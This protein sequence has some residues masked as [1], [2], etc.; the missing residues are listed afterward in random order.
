[1]NNSDASPVEMAFRLFPLAL[2]EA[3]QRRNVPYFL[4]YAPVQ[5]FT[6][7]GKN[8]AKCGGVTVQSGSAI[9]LV[10]GIVMRGA[11]MGDEP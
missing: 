3:R 8:Q 10:Q 9:N 2:F 1:M 4:T 6:C 5:F 11:T 7:I